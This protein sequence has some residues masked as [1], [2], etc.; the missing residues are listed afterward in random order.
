MFHYFIELGAGA[1]GRDSV[2][3][4]IASIDIGISVG[5]IVVLIRCIIDSREVIMGIVFNTYLLRSSVLVGA[6]KLLGWLHCVG[7][8]MGLAPDRYL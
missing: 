4:V 8:G 6:N 1:G 3:G 7:F 2:C 5:V